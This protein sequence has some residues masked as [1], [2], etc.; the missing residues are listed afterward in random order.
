M[1]IIYTGRT[2]KPEYEEKLCAEYLPLDELLRRSDFV[3]LNCALTK[4]TNGALGEREL[5]MMKKDAAYKYCQGSCCRSES[6][7]QCM[8][9]RLELGGGA[10][11][12]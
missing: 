5:R 7:V 9:G 11:C 12:V 2:R 4:E 10:R 1:K 8:L 3:S 6:A